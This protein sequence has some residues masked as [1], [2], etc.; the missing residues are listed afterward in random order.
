M[1]KV[2]DPSASSLEQ[3]S[4]LGEDAF[5]CRPNAALCYTLENKLGKITDMQGCHYPTIIFFSPPNIPGSMFGVSGLGQ[6]MR[7]GRSLSQMRGVLT[8][9]RTHK[10]LLLF[11]SVNCK[12]GF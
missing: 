7:Q 4:E 12:L 9:C 2:H 5:V 3:L 6:Y 11:V 1:L 10:R 8:V